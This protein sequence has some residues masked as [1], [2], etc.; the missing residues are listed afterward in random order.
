[1]PASFGPWT[2][3]GEPGA[4]ADSASSSQRPAAKK[5]D[6]SRRASTASDAGTA[7]NHVG[8]STMAV[9]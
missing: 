2:T 3:S 9:S 4:V 7:E 6:W 5:P 8:G 1:V